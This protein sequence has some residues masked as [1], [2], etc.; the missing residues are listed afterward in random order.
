M[1]LSQLRTFLALANTG[2]VRAT[3]E[4]LFVSQPAVSSAVAALQGELGVALVARQGRGLRITPAGS[5]LAAY[6]SQL[7]GLMD[8]AKAATR[9]AA[10][11]ERGRLRL[12]AVTTAGEHV[13]P[14]LLAS[15]RAAHPDASIVLEVGNRTRV[16]ELLIE[17]RVDLAIG[18]RPPDVQFVTLATRAHELIVVGNTTAPF[19]GRRQATLEELAQRTWLMRE[20]GS[21][22]R[23][24]A[25][26]ILENLGIHPPT[27]TLSSNV[28]IVESVRV[29]LGVALLSRDAVERELHAGTLF[30]WAFG[31]LPL[32]R[33]WHLVARAN[34]DLP[35]T[36]ALFVQ[37]LTEPGEGAPS[38]FVRADAPPAA[39]KPKT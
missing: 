14:T 12:A 34:G 38:G 5:A 2:S 22:S 9:A 20:R 28:A 6:A 8:E 23:A 17:H 16:W 18:G 26:E 24:T 1:T 19:P 36:A 30:E 7:L 39:R 10:A 15:F 27:L 33:E 29:G 31:P 11:P 32:R 37:H 25:D 21:G 3:A 4:A 35:A 13:V